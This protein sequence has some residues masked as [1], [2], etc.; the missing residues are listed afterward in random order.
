MSLGQTVSA[1][2]LD[3]GEPALTSA[4]THFF[5]LEYILRFSIE[6]KKVLINQYLVIFYSLGMCEQDISS[7]ISKNLFND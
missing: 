3:F 2:K 6:N 1:S 4:L 7:K 5:L